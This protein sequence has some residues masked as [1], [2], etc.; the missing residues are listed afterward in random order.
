MADEISVRTVI[1][2][3]IKPLLP[4]RW[5]LLD[6]S[7]N[8]DTLD[9]V[10]VTTSI[11][12][13]ERAPEV[14]KNARWYF[15]TLRVEEPSHDIDAVDDLLDDEIIDLLNAIDD[16]ARADDAPIITWTTAER[17]VTKE[18][19]GNFAFDVTFKMLYTRKEST[20]A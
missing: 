6:N 2:D 12:R 17:G 19:G 9:R 8:L 13:I 14:A 20:R 11:Q 7:P 1:I 4:G 3:T 15:G 10:T 5:R 18:E 16:L